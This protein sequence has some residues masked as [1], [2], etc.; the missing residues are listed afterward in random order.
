VEVADLREAV[1][2]KTSCGSVA[3]GEALSAADREARR[4]TEGSV[5]EEYR[6]GDVNIDE[7]CGR[8]RGVEDVASRGGRESRRVLLGVRDR[9]GGG[10]QVPERVRLVEEHVFRSSRRYS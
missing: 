3:D 9:D 8:G 2:S 5:E 4:G 10:M 6:L 1:S 7:T